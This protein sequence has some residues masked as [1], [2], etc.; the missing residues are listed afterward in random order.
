MDCITESLSEPCQTTGV[1][2]LDFVMHGILRARILPRT[3]E[4]NMNT[5][6]NMYLSGSSH[7]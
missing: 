7:M 5:D 4:I 6:S 3:T 1:A 2:Q